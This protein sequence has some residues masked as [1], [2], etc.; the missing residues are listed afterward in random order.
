MER[1]RNGGWLC[2]DLTW[3][4]NHLRYLALSEE[5]TQIRLKGWAGFLLFTYRKTIWSYCIATFTHTVLCKVN[6]IFS[7]VSTRSV[8]KMPVV[9]QVNDKIAR[10]E[11]W[12]EH[13]I[14]SDVGSLLLSKSLSQPQSWDKNVPLHVAVSLWHENKN[15][16]IIYEM[17]EEIVKLNRYWKERTSITQI[18]S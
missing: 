16:L 7:H 14:S 10:K 17:L 8:F 12:F 3:R 18:I 5:V 11:K 15:I 1:Y 2:T 4:S 6:D 9:Q 13:I